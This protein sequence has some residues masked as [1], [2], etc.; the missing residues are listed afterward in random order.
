MNTIKGLEGI[1]NLFE[2]AYRC[3]LAQEVDE[4][5]SLS[6]ATVCSWQAGTLKRQ[7]G[8]TP[9][10]ILLPGYPLS[11]KFV[12]PK[13]LPRRSLKT[14]EGRVALLH[15]LAHI[16]FNAIN[17]AW[18][19][20]YRFRNLPSAFYEDWIKI[21][22]E[23][24]AHFLLLHEQL[25]ALGYQYGDLPAH[26]GLWEMA[27]KTAHDVLIRMALVPRGLEARGLDATPG[28][29]EKVKS[30]KLHKLVDIL[31]IILRD[32]IGH[33]A[34]GSK[35]FTFLC[36]ERGV[37]STV[38]FQKL[39][40]EY[41]KGDLKGPLNRSARLEAGFT[42]EELTSLEQPCLCLLSP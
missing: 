11:L 5:I 9:E 12:R 25:Q 24:T 32:E 37:G 28:L 2:G 23:E 42:E 29:I 19:A 30:M 8:G 1:D 21:A 20:V 13:D 18:D 22:Q 14:L 31:S 15:A 3:I 10:E 17:L 16:E 7:G 38:T 6:Q 36:Q 34:V 35:W 41:F 4:K 27:V 33:V 39:M 40:K 26:Q